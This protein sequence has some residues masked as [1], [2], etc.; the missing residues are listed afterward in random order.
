[1][2]LE[3]IRSPKSIR[4]PFPG[5]VLPGKVLDQAIME[6]AKAYFANGILQSYQE[7]LFTGQEDLEEEDLNEAEE[8]DESD[9]FYFSEGPKL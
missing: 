8:L 7:S 5:R 4:R 3:P 1:M 9:P 2:G 6:S